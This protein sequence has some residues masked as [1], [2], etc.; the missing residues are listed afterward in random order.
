M[1]PK[2]NLIKSFAASNVTGSERKPLNVINYQLANNL[3]NLITLCAVC[4]KTAEWEYVKEHPPTTIP[5]NSKRLPL[6]AVL[7]ES[8]PPEPSVF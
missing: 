1:Y 5:L 2:A 7:L 3:D 6:L 4:H 8:D